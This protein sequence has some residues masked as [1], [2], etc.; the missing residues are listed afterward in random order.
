MV[1]DSNAKWMRVERP[2]PSG[3]PQHPQHQQQQQEEEEEEGGGREG[4]QQRG[5]RPNRRR[6]APQS[7]KTDGAIEATPSVVTY[8]LGRRTSVER[9]STETGGSDG[10]GGGGGG[11]GRQSGKRMPRDVKDRMKVL[12]RFIAILKG[13]SP[14]RNGNP[15]EEVA[16]RGSAGERRRRRQQE[17]A[18]L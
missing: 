5:C 12:P 17:G 4:Q 13:A 9:S 1:V 7:L 6:H 11:G 15:T 16:S 18:V 3:G 2:S 10:G 8:S 14:S